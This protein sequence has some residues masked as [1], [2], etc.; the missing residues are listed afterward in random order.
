MPG[1]VHI[2]K[3]TADL[4]TQ[5]GKGHWLTMREDKIV[6]KGKG[7][8][9]TY[10]YVTKNGHIHNVLDIREVS[11]HLDSNFSGSNNNSVAPILEASEAMMVPVLLLTL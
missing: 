7:E 10:W 9:Q 3:E 1:F 2:S 6:A 11:H 4:V 8:M 5:A